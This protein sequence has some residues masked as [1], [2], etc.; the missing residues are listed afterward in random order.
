MYL[1]TSQKVRCGMEQLL[2]LGFLGILYGFGISG[3]VWLFGLLA[4]LCYS[5]IF[6]HND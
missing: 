1:P 3:I 4:S 5:A 6:K 2:Q